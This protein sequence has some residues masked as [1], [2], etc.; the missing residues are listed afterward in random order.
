MT[1]RTRFCTASIVNGTVEFTFSDGNQLIVDP[2][3]LSSEI[4]DQATLLGLL[5][6]VRDSYAD[7]EN[8]RN[9]DEEKATAAYRLASARLTTLQAGKWNV[10]RQS[11]IRFLAEALAEAT[12]K[13]LTAI[14]EKLAGMEKAEKKAFS[15]KPKV[16]KI[17]ARLVIE[18]NQRKIDSLDGDDE[19]EVE[20]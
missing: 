3:M 17:I 5:N 4:N 10:E 8:L 16:A 13:S 19:E 6:T 14:R 7:V 11:E 9:V 12:G 18:A 20:L 15:E 1:K 2:A